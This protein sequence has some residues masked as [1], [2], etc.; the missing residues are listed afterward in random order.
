MTRAIALDPAGGVVQRN[1][2]GGKR[3]ARSAGLPRPEAALSAKLGPGLTRAVRR[4]RQGLAVGPAAANGLEARADGTA[5]AH[6][7][8]R[9]RPG[10]ADNAAANI[11][12]VGGRVGT[13]LGTVMTAT[14]P[15]A[16]LE[17]IASVPAVARL[18][19]ARQLRYNLDVS[20]PDTGADAV[21]AGT[22]GSPGALEGSG[23]IVGVVDSGVDWEHDDFR[24]PDGT[25]R[26]LY[27]WDQ[28]DLIGPNPTEFAYGTEWTKAQIDD[29]L[30]GTPPGIVR[31]T[32]PIEHG[33]HVAGIA[34]SNGRAPGGLVGVAPEADLIVV[35][36]TMYDT[37][38]VDGI[39]YIFQK[40]AAAGKPAVV[41]VSLGANWGPHDNTSPYETSLNALIG[42]GRIVAIAA[43]NAGDNFVDAG[44]VQWAAH[45]SYTNSVGTW[46]FTAGR[47]LDTFYLDMWNEG[48]TI[49]VAVELHELIDSTLYF[50]DTTPDVAAGTSGAWTLQNGATN[51]GQVTIDSTTT[52]DPGNGDHNI[53]IEVARIVPEATF[54]DYF[55]HVWTRGTGTVDTWIAFEDAALFYDLSHLGAQL[56]D[57]SLTVSGGATAA[58]VLAIA[59]YV[60]QLGGSSTTIGDISDFSSIGPSRK[61]ANTGLKPEIGAPGEIIN[62]ARPGGGHQYYQG[63]SMSCPHITGTVALMLELDPSLTPADCES[64]LASSARTDAF[65]GAVPNDMWGHGKVDALATMIAVCSPGQDTIPPEVTCRNTTVPLDGTGHAS[66]VPADVFDSGSDNCG[67]VNLVSVVPNSFD[68]DDLGENTVTLTVDDGNGNVNTCP[69]TV[70]VT[71]PG[72]ACLPAVP[73]V[74]REGMPPMIILMFA[75][76]LL[77]LAGR[78]KKAR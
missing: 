4:H 78:R 7:F 55:W 70:T 23:V 5:V 74:S 25:S 19:A 29:E 27:I 50:R 61:P 72:D 59:S 69:A 32:D 14:V 24:N 45:T 21:H 75:S 43:G 6:V 2:G 51:V 63:T 12:A 34:A 46:K 47:G 52:S 3:P 56:V 35:K 54:P 44:Y 77:V 37:T 33:T 76:G 49:E 9:P 65:T 64:L 10:G 73:A 11:R 17:P 18:E 60:T 58:D 57:A 62:S 8:V 39:D 16:Q 67:T 71:D 41:N 38:I 53:L 40:A 1:A 13:V 36:T 20:V 48:G 42:P 15:V 30:D 66:I 31:E 22:G 26:L 28:T 68:C